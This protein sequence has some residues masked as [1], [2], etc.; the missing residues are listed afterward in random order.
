MFVA[1]A[2]DAVLVL[3]LAFIV[4]VVFGGAATRLW[5]WMPFLHI[6]AVVWAVHVELAG[7]QC[8]L[9]PLENSLRVAAGQ[10]GYGESFIEHYLLAIIYPKGLTGS[11]Q[12]V[13]AGAVIAINLAVYG[14][15]VHG[16]LSR[17]LQRSD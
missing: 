14:A 1:V 5:R 13:L 2:A 17:R 3:H 12:L 11:V 8:P 10:T 7:R 4:F 6:P 16:W 15:L 9:T